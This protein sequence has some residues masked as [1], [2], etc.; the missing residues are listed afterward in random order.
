MSSMMQSARPPRVSAFHADSGIARISRHA[1]LA[2]SLPV[3][4]ELQPAA[5]SEQP[6]LDRL[7]E[8]TTLEDFIHQ[9]LAPDLNDLALLAPARFRAT[10]AATRKDV[11]R[12][13]GKHRALARR[14]GMLAG[15]LDEQDELVRLAQLYCSALVQG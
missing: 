4:A 13:A 7:F 2:V 11:L 9:R 5:L 14:L 10:L 12:Q 1:G 15:L 6:Q 8:M 3:R